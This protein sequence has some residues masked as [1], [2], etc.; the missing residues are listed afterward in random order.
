MQTH[1]HW[2]SACEGGTLLD[3]LREVESTR[4]IA[5]GRL[6]YVVELLELLHLRLEDVDA[7]VSESLE[8]WELSRI[9]RIDRAV[10][11]IG[12]VEMLFVD[13]VHPK[14]AIQEAVRI[15][16]AYGGRSSPGFVNGVLDGVYRA[17][18]SEARR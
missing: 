7:A 3:A 13:D 16:D 11:R 4:R 18:R 1:Y 2:E 14:V 5:P 6:S 17:S 10:L 9:S 15:A 8:N 12:C